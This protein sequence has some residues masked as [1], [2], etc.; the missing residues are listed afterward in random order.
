MGKRMPL[1]SLAFTIGA[2]SLVGLP[3]FIG[4]PSKFLIVRAALAREANL[5]TIL[6]GLVLL[7]TV[8]EGAYFFRVVQ[9][10]Y[11]RK[12]HGNMERKDAPVAALIPM[13]IFIVLI[14]VIGVY[15]KLVTRIL[16]SAA[17]ELLNRLDYIRSVLG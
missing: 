7:G 1:T 11:Y 14:I 10:L 4:F 15:P 16:N 6:I 13:A 12:A 2:F 9:V 3:P 5:F 17:S 8:I